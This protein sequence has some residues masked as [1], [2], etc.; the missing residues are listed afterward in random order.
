[1]AQPSTCKKIAT[2][3]IRTLRVRTVRVPMTEPHRTA[4]GVIQE[5]PL[6]LTDLETD[7]GVTGHSIVFTYTVLA[8]QATAELIRN[9][10]SLLQRQP[11]APSDLSDNLESRFRLLGTQGLMG[12]ALSAI[13][14]AAW[15]AQ[16]RIQGCSLAVLLGGVPREIQAYGAVGF[17]GAG[18]SAAAAARWAERGFKGVKAKIGYETVEEDLAVIRAIRRAVGRSVSIMVDYNQLLSPSAAIERIRCLEGEGL[19]W[20]EEPVRS[21]DFAGHAKVATAVETPIQ[22]GENWWGPLEVEHAI[23]QQSTDYLMFDAMKIGGVTGWLRSQ[24]LAAQKGIRVSNHLFPEWS[25]QMLSVTEN[26][27]WLEYADW[28][29][30]VLREPLR[31]E[32]GIAKPDTRPGSGIEWNEEA[33]RG[34]LA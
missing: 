16:A 2:E 8:L 33:I 14:M 1:M 9:C 3:E 5:C 13:D 4:G 11:L 6:V 27:H 15:D 29:N 23:Q 17:E 32:N 26:A 12:M 18:G 21:H 7:N 28:W 10:A 25:A 30:P 20:V 31:I 19:A 34:M 22:A 24:Q